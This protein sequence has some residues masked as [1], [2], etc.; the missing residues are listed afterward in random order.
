[1]R[2]LWI[3]TGFFVTVMMGT[4]LAGYAVLFGRQTA[5]SEGPLMET[6][7]RIG[8]AA[9]RPRESDRLRRRLGQAG[10]RSPA[11]S[12]VYSGIRV[13]SA[14]LIGLILFATALFNT[15][16]LYSAVLAALCGSLVGFIL[17]QMVLN[18]RI[19]QRSPTAAR[20]T[21]DCA[22]FNGTRPRSRPVPGRRLPGNHARAAR[23]IPRS[24][25]G[26]DPGI[27]R[28]LRRQEPCRCVPQP[29]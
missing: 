23:A 2:E 3:L 10:Y 5:G 16:S 4:G 7:G 12:P 18:R 22:G 14:A 26:A 25:R 11:A 24:E 8:L 19:Q 9:V 28:Y 27:A 15:G 29:G 13:A 6:L 21:A 17:P 1:M 20:R